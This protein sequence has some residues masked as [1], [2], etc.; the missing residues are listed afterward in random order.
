MRNTVGWKG[1]NRVDMGRKKRLGTNTSVLHT[2]MAA[3]ETVSLSRTVSLA[4][5]GGKRVW[6][7]GESFLVKP[8]LLT[9]Y[10]VREQGAFDYGGSAR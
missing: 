4:H 9:H 8:S 6:E 2:G 3:R 7:R 1:M 5:R 10:N